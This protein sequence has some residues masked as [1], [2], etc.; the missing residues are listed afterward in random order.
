MDLKAADY[1]RH[2]FEH[3]IK[4]HSPWNPEKRQ[5]LASLFDL[6]EVEPIANEYEARQRRHLPQWNSSETSDDKWV[7]AELFQVEPEE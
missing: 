2:I 4:I 1:L 5:A 6:D 3:K 7:D